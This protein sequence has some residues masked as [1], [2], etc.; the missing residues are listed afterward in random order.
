MKIVSNSSRIKALKLF[1]DNDNEKKFAKRMLLSVCA[2]LTRLN[3]TLIGFM[4]HILLLSVL[5]AAYAS[6]FHS[7]AAFKH[8]SLAKINEI[9][10]N[11]P[12]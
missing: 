11:H 4:L 7:F 12:I 1:K 6:R 5:L 2:R 9:A 10:R 3:R 8:S